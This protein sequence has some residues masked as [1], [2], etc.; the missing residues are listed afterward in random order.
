MSA[1]GVVVGGS[2]AAVATPGPAVETSAVPVDGHEELVAKCK[3]DGAYAGTRAL[4][5]PIPLL[6]ALVCPLCQWR[7]N[8]VPG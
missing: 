2:A 7:P 1:G 3:V 4:L 8:L 6:P 5:S